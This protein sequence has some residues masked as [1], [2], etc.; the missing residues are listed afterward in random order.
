M[1]YIVEITEELRRELTV[2]AKSREQ[3]YEIAKH[4][5]D[6]EEIVLGGDDCVC[7]EISVRLGGEERG[8]GWFV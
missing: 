3:A 4:K 8:Y 7:T 5:Y 6:K 1:K 2:E